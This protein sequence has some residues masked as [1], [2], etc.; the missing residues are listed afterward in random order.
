MSAVRRCLVAGVLILAI[1]LVTALAGC[2]GEPESVAPPESVASPDLELICEGEGSPT[3]VMGSGLGGSAADYAALQAQLAG[4]T[5]VCRYSR[6][7]L[8]QSPPW[9][10]DL[11]DP[12]AGTAADQ[13]RAT[14]DEHDVPEPYVLLG[15][16]YG[17]LV[18]QAFAARHGDAVA[19]VVLEDA[20]TPEI[21]DA[22]EWEGFSW[23]E[24]G[25]MIDT[26]ATADEVR[27][28][29]L[30]DLPLIVL[31]QGTME[32]WPDPALW[33]SIQ[34][35]LATLSDDVVHVVATDAGHAI[36][37][38]VPALVAQAVEDVV[39][40]VRSDE[41]LPECDD[42]DWLPVGGA[43]RAP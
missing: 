14:L 33:T 30:G 21:F 23:E 27:D 20:A 3:V 10:A 38:D 7:G 4:V 42:Q 28:V 41:P 9:G 31:T 39:E 36:H 34:D 5:Q 37:F 35:R 17:G 15:W 8:G 18:A 13:L 25:R 29:D 2:S 1:P 12:S 26:Q 6:A 40:A 19:G 22:P 43:C 24:G 16:S 32:D 11:D